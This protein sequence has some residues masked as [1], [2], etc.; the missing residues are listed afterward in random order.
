[1]FTFAILSQPWRE[2][3]RKWRQPNGSPAAHRLHCT[4]CRWAL[5]I[6]RKG[7]HD[8]IAEVEAYVRE[9]FAAVF[10]EVYFDVRTLASLR[11]TRPH[12]DD[13]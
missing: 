2:P 5:C 1:M 13:T 6:A 3:H 7:L 4:C 9:N 12:I 8:T 11:A 10:P